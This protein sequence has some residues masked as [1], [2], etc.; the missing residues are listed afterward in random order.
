MR[1]CAGWIARVGGRKDLNRAQRAVGRR[2]AL[3]LMESDCVT[4]IEA[5]AGR[6]QGKRGRNTDIS[7]KEV[8][9]SLVSIYMATWARAA[10]LSFYEVSERSLRQA[11]Q[12]V[13]L[14]LSS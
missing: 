13:G 12:L 6:S 11:A 8:Q 2:L 10:E 14:N 5:V 7:L 1:G 9:S 4:G 3:S